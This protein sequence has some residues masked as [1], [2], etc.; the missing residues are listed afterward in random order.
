MQTQLQSRSQV[1][2]HDIFLPIPMKVTSLSGEQ[3]ISRQGYSRV[4][5]EGKFVKLPAFS[6]ASLFLGGS[7]FKSSHCSFDLDVTSYS[8]VRDQ[9]MHDL[10][11]S[12]PLW[13]AI[14]LS[15]FMNPK[16]A[17]NIADI[18]DSLQ[19]TSSRVRRTLFSQG[20]CFTEIC[21][22]QRLMRSLFELAGLERSIPDISNRIG[23]SQSYDFETSFYNRFK[24]SADVI[25][26]MK[27]YAR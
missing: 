12:R 9:P 5:K 16:E 17:W 19:T 15:V 23:W 4:I 27:F 24:V 8:V 10:W 11:D 21:N 25:C 3:I 13:E 18:A 6:P 22:T 2:I 20:N 1:G 26:G 7:I 14:S